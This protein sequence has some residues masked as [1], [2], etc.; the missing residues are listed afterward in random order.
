[1]SKRIHHHFSFN[2]K[3][4]SIFV[5]STYIL[6]DE[7]YRVLFIPCRHRHHHTKYSQSVSWQNYAIVKCS[8]LNWSDAVLL[9]LLL[10]LLLLSVS[11][12]GGMVKRWRASSLKMNVTMT[13]M[14]IY[15]VDTN[16]NGN[17]NNHHKHNNDN[18]NAT[19]PNSRSISGCILLGSSGSSS[20]IMQSQFANRKSNLSYSQCV[21][22]CV[23][24]S[25]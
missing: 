3:F 15:D 4:S 7:C 17:N 18:S 22:V 8:W 21:R 24:V 10:L 20:I 5:Y 1:M 23:S 11:L 2:F 13:M 14:K 6:Y 25:F 19:E 16:R 12:F 9:P